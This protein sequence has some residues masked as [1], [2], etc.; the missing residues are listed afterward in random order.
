MF[1]ADGGGLDAAASYL[2]LTSTKLLSDLRSG[3]SLAQIATAQGK[4]ASGLES[5]MTAAV[6]TR[7]DK[8][9]AAKTITS[10]Q[11]Q[12]FLSRLSAMLNAIVNRTGSGMPGGPDFHGAFARPPA[13]SWNHGGP[14]SPPLVP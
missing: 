6:K 8:A 2:G 9:V 11:E 1:D 4:T 5:A 13:G 7:L 14:G 12:Q 10:A 3:K